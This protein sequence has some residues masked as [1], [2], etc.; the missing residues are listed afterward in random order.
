MR[1]L[2][3]CETILLMVFKNKGG[4]VVNVENFLTLIGQALFVL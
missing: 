2:N 3:L 4:I 1:F